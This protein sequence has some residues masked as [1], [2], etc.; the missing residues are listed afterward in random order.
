MTLPVSET[1]TQ[2]PLN[3]APQESE[4]IP[5]VSVV[6]ENLEVPWALAIL[7][8]GGMFLTERGGRVRLVD[9]TGSLQNE[10][11]AQ[12]DSVRQ[13]GE[14][15]LHGIV[16]HPDFQNNRFVYVYYTY[17]GS[18]NNTMNR[19]VRYT[20]QNNRLQNEEMIV[21]QI[22]GASTHDGG[23][24][25]FGPDG[26]LY[27][28]TGDA[29]EPSLSQDRNSLAGKILRVTDT[30]EPA[31]G[32]PFRTRIYSYGHRNPQGIAWDN[33]GN[34]WSTEHG[35]QAF[36]ELNRIAAGANYGWPTVRGNQ[37]QEA[38]NP[39]HMHSGNDTWA[40]SGLAYLD[41][42]LYFAGLRGEALYR[43]RVGSTTQETF[44]KGELG[45]LREAVAGPDGMLYISTSNRDGRG[46]PR[47]G[48][49]K[50]LR[51]NPEKL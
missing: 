23:R 27:I 40:P 11:V 6:A 5:Q 12:I 2:I 34:L 19:V 16:L 4:D 3:E 32:N 22:P 10:P 41:G 29:Q 13:I 50:I 15:G 9:R 45:R 48:D 18:G 47:A 20:F 25:K 35:S 14:G 46:R 17:A 38:M 51:I 24:I 26:F 49:D 7:P 28:T 42:Y 21:D 44:F 36:D 1:V 43:V 30:G 8:E 31:P 37:S 33:D 39:P